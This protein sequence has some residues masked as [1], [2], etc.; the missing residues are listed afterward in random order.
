MRRDLLG[1]EDP[2]PVPDENP[3]LDFRINLRGVTLGWLMQIFRM[4]HSTVKKKLVDCPEVGKGRG[5]TPLFDVAQ[6]AS[7][8]VK[9]KVDIRTW[10][11]QLRPSDLPPYMQSEF[12][13]AQNKRQKWEENA[14][15]LWRTDK[16]IEVFADTFKTMK[17]TMNLWVDNIERKSG[18]TAE[19]RKML[20]ELVDSLQVELHGKLVDM[21]SDK[22]TFSSAADLENIEQESADAE[23][24]KFQRPRRELV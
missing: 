4:D 19:Q 23:R 21:Q 12:W 2:I 8:L 15:E 7:Y 13:E 9:P 6:A 14:G 24:K 3:E 1:K 10:M 22:K 20:I 17:E 16:V 5:G 11:K 18:L